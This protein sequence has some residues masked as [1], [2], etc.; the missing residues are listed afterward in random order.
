MAIL[1]VESC[2]HGWVV[3]LSSFCILGLFTNTSKSSARSESQTCQNDFYLRASRVILGLHQQHPSRNALDVPE[4]C[5]FE[6]GGE[7]SANKIRTVRFTYG[8]GLEFRV[9]SLGLRV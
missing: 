5:S 2:V 8:L 4:P 9:K 6:H 3:C 1:R 7:Q